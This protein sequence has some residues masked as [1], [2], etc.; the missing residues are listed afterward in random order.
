MARRPLF[1]QTCADLIEQLT[2]AADE[3]AA[4]GSHMA[5]SVGTKEFPAALQR[6]TERYHCYLEINER[7]REHRELAHARTESTSA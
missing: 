7:L 2:K 6:R 1:C 4:A 3:A 5:A